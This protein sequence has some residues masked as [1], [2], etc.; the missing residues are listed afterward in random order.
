M[1]PKKFKPLKRP[2]P[3]RPPPPQQEDTPPSERQV[4]TSRSSQPQRVIEQT[5]PPTTDWNPT[6]FLNFFPH[7]REYYVAKGEL[8]DRIVRTGRRVVTKECKC[9]GCSKSVEVLTAT[10]LVCEIVILVLMPSY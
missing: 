1:P 5:T 2:P 8:S 10:D 3:S 7:M 4:T 6:T 9:E